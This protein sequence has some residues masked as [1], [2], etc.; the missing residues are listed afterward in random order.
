MF[1][2]SWNKTQEFLRREEIKVHQLWDSEIK[3]GCL[4]L[5]AALVIKL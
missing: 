1:M 5:R 4:N 2:G 3:F